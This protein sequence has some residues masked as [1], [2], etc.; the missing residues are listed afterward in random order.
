MKFDGPLALVPGACSSGQAAACGH[1]LVLE[2]Q[3]I[4]ADLHDGLGAS[5]IA[6]LRHVQSG[7]ADQASIEQCVHEALQEMRIAID[8]LRPHDNDL[9]TVLGNLRYRLD[10]SI[11]ASGMHFQWQVEELPPVIGLDPSMVFSIQRILLEAITN[12]FKHSGAARL[13]VLACAAGR[14]DIEIRIEDDGCGFDAS[15]PARGQ[16][17]A[18]MYA[19]AAQLGARIRIDS[20]PRHGTS[21]RLMIPCRPARGFSDLLQLSS[22]A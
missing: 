17:L 8:A 5:L 4:L 20:R 11:R 3:R 13:S 14:R 2:R 15:T 6:L 10:N 21:V 16:G 12:V 7:Q 18:N 19:R 22:T 9:G 1:E